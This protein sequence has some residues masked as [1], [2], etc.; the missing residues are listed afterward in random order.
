MGDARD[1]TGFQRPDQLCEAGIGP[2]APIQAE[3]PE[4]HQGAEGVDGDEAEIRAQIGGP[5]LRIFEV[6]PGQQRQE[7][8]AVDGDEIID[9]HEHRQDL[10]LLR[11]TFFLLMDRLFS[12][13]HLFPFGPAGGPALSFFHAFGVRSAFHASMA[14]SMFCRLS[15]HGAAM[16]AHTSVPASCPRGQDGH[17]GGCPLRSPLAGAWA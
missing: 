7:I 15:G 8:G 1:Q 17:P 10:P 9:S 14:K 6:K 5:D 2:Q 3:E 12:V 16:A 4:H 11:H 13:F